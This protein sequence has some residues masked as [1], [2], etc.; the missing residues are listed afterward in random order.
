MALRESESI[1]TKHRQLPKL[2]ML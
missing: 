1:I 2:A